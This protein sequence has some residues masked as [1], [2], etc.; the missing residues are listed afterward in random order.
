[1]FETP[2]AA[3]VVGRG[4]NWL[5]RFLLASCTFFVSAAVTLDAAAHTRFPVAQQLLIDPSNQARLWART[6][7]GLLTSPDSGKSWDWV[8]QDSVGYD[9]EFD[10]KLAMTKNSRVFVGAKEGLFSTASGGC[11]WSKAVGVDSGEI[12]DVTVEADGQH[13]LALARLPADDHYS[14]RLFR[15]DEKGAQFAAVGKPLAEDLLGRSL[16][17]A[18]ASAQ[19]LYATGSVISGEGKGNAAPADVL[20]R[21][22]DA[23]QSWQRLDIP[24]TSLTQPA[25]LLG[26][27]PKDADKLYLRVIGETKTGG[28]SENAVFYSSDAGDTW[29][30]VFRTAG[31]VLGFAASA[32]VKTVWLGVGDP[33]DPNGRRTVD[34]G[35]LGIYVASTS[36]LSF[37]QRYVGHVGCV[38]QNS[39]GLYVCGAHEMDGFELGISNDEGTT[40]TPLFDFG[41]ARG[42]LECNGKPV[43]ACEAHWEHDC[44][45]LGTC[46][47]STD[48]TTESEGRASTPQTQGCSLVAAGTSACWGPLFSVIAVAGLIGTRLRRRSQPRRGR[49][50]SGP[51]VPTRH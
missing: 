4:S 12:A 13:A 38:N 45:L 50:D 51:E 28:F 20:L 6:S 24:G 41:E 18:P 10:P 29:S 22:Y 36:D 1:M 3:S 11:G 34:P 39:R 42:V 30:E 47:A 26:V 25:L 2:T 32:D 46:S 44:S 43:T 15:S 49:R 31:D 27:D 48:A 7:Y 37:E 9:G 21:S 33:H 17:V 35:V 19:R 16:A 8:C 14:L 23:G 5:P 40:V